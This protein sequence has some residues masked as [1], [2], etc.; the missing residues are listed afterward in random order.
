MGGARHTTYDCIMIE[1]IH[2]T[3]MLYTPL[4]KWTSP[5]CSGTRPPPCC[6]CTLTMFSE[7]E[8]VLFGGDLGD[9]VYSNHMYTVHVPTMVSEMT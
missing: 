1:V 8:A 3:C 2:F 4:G 7:E 6:Y 5:T 9:L